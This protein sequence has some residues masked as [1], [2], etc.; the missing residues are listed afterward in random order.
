MKV[1]GKEAAPK[2]RKPQCGVRRTSE[3]GART[4]CTNDGVHVNVF[5]EFGTQVK[6][7]CNECKTRLTKMGW[8]IRFQ[9]EGDNPPEQ[10]REIMPGHD[11]PDFH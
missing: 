6:V 11:G 2:E 7:M 5:G 4:Q 10:S 8:K 9:L 3:K 1:N